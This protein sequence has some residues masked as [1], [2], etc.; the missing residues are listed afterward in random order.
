M[1]T[2]TKTKKHTVW[3]K[4]VVLVNGQASG[5]GRPSEGVKGT[6]TCVYIQA[7]KGVGVG[8]VEYGQ[9]IAQTSERPYN[10]AK[11]KDQRPQFKRTNLSALKPVIV[12]QPEPVA[13]E[14]VAVNIPTPEV[15]AV[16]T[17][18]VETA[19]AAA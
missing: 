2:E 8:R 17:E 3:V 14:P 5:K 7:P 10:P 4:R 9:H 18:T 11:N 6:R 19:P 12:N 1:S 15:V 16:V 13:A